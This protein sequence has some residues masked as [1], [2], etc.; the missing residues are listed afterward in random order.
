MSNA[1]FPIYQC[2]SLSTFLSSYN[3]SDPF[4]WGSV[5]CWFNYFFKYLKCEA[6]LICPSIV[7]TVCMSIFVQMSS[8]LLNEVCSPTCCSDLCIESV[9]NTQWSTKA[10]QATSNFLP[11]FKGF[12]TLLSFSWFSSSLN[13]SGDRSPFFNPIL[14][15]K[16]SASSFKSH[17]GCRV[18]V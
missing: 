16:L 9:S 2:Y 6:L 14:F 1:V 11:T 18:Y 8:D 10:K 4:S 5:V 17:F 7:S 13:I 3:C 12:Q 15:W